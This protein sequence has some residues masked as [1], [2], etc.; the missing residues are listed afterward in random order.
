LV[1]YL[2]LFVAPLNLRADYYY[3]VTQSILEPRFLLAVVILG[4]LVG[5]MLTNFR[6]RPL[7]SYGLAWF[8]LTKSVE[9]IGVS[10][11]L[12]NLI[13]ENWLYLSMVGLCLLAAYVLTVVIR[14]A[15]LLNIIGVVLVGV[16]GLSAYNR[17]AVWVTEIGHYQDLVAKEPQFPAAY[18]GLADA[19]T[20]KGQ[21]KMALCS[22]QQAVRLKPDFTRALNNLGIIY[23][24]QGIDSAAQEHFERA[25]HADADFFPAYRN[26]GYLAYLRKD[27]AQAAGAYENYLRYVP[28]AAEGRY[29][30][31]LSYLQL[32]QKD[33]A[34]TAF[35]QAREQALKDHSAPLVASIEQAL[36]EL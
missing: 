2:R 13:Y 29:Y 28:T 23:A 24:G 8:F 3:P 17:N 32:G 1:T 25:L 20:R 6:K 21:Q 14:R 7:I 33:K 35:I 19:Y 26:L 27:Y 22:L 15:V 18:L 11:G 4:A 30:L 16:L 5:V 34:R 36:G 10:F 31:G 12:R 9:F